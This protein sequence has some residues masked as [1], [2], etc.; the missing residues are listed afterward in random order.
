[1]SKQE[2]KREFS[3]KELLDFATEVVK[4]HGKVHQKGHQMDPHYVATVDESAVKQYIVN[5]FMSEGDI[6][7]YFL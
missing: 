5:L 3:P 7:K 1:M 4:N 6:D 2:L